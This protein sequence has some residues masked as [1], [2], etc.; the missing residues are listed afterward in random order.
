MYIDAIDHMLKY[1]LF[2]QNSTD[3]ALLKVAYTCSKGMQN[4]W[5]Q[6]ANKIIGLGTS[7]KQNINNTRITRKMIQT[8]N[9]I[10]RENYKKWWRNNLQCDSKTESE[11]GRKL[12]T[13]QNI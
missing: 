2:I 11:H 13:L 10:L 8:V 4:D 1:T 12:R 9:R 5:V 7:T 6:F 3:N